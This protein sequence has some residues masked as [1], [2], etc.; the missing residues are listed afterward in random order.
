M[1]PSRS[2]YAATTLCNHTILR[3]PVIFIRYGVGKSGVVDVP[4]SSTT[5]RYRASTSR[6]VSRQ[7][8]EKRLEIPTKNESSRRFSRQRKANLKGSRRDFSHLKVIRR[9]TPTDKSFP[10]RVSRQKKIPT[11]EAER[12]PSIRRLRHFI[13]YALVGPYT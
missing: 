13:S 5:L 8:M 3:Y 10:C 4:K 1:L 12:Y 2:S 9:G 11:V 6:S 7:K